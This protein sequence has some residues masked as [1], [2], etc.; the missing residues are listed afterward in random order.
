MTARNRFYHWTRARAGL[1]AILLPLALAAL[2]C[3]FQT[4]QNDGLRQTDIALGVQQTLLAQTAS[5]LS[6]EGSKPTTIA[7]VA[8]ATP[9]QPT[10]TSGAAPIA[11]KPTDT[12]I[13][14]PAPSDTP[15]QPTSASASQEEILITEW[16]LNFFNPINSGCKVPNTG[17]WA[18]NDD[19]KKHSGNELSLVSKVPVLIDPGWPRP[20]L[21]FWH[22]YTFQKTARVDISGNGTW[23]TMLI[24]NQQKSSDVWKPGAID[25]SM[26][27]GKE[28]LINFAAEGKWLAHPSIPGSDWII[29]DVRIVP[30]YNP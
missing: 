27:K 29:N 12:P 23:S 10:A 16:K 14:T 25:L 3:N 28:I 22:K 1:L 13:P 7:V 18:M 9:A 4:Q 2:A 5:A 24:L 6:V 19:F 15:A 11:D 17:C 8:S 20:Y 26:F 30:N 21:V